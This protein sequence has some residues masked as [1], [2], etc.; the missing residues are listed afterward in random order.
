M[1]ISQ[2]RQI[3]FVEG[4][5]FFSVVAHR[6]AVYLEKNHYIDTTVQ[7]AGFQASLVA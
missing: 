5:I 4:K 1:D 3:S 6:L 7:K 2:F